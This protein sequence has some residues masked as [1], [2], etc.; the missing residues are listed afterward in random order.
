MFNPFSLFDD[1]IKK[2]IKRF[3]LLSNNFPSQ[4]AKFVLVSNCGFNNEVNDLKTSSQN[5]SHTAQL[6]RKINRFTRTME[7]EC[8]LSSATV[9]NVLSKLEFLKAPQFTD[10]DSKIIEAHLGNIPICKGLNLDVLRQILEEIKHLVYNASSKRISEP[11]NDY[12]SFIRKGESTK[13][14]LEIEEK[15]ITVAKV[16]GII[17]KNVDSIN[18]INASKDSLLEL[19][20]ID[21]VDDKKDQFPQLDIKIR[22]IGDR[23][24][25][26]K[27]A[28]IH[29]IRTWVLLNPWRPRAVRIS[30]NYNVIL[31]FQYPNIEIISLSQAIDPNDVDRFTL[32]LGSD[33]GPGPNKYV[34]QLYLLLLY[35]GDNKTIQ[36][37]D[38]LI[39]SRSPSKILGARKH[40]NRMEY[41]KEYNKKVLAEIKSI[42][43]I[44]S[45]TLTQIIK[46]YL[47]SGEVP[48]P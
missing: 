13:F 28:E 38:M 23:I 1:E 9:S 10:I 45:E 6:R 37:Q 22:N 26:L 20:D 33:Q 19:V 14:N 11:V 30:C 27:R 5:N 2:S 15:R 21:I 35:D 3:I 48:Y 36:T 34:Y 41:C 29:V 7:D 47:H 39:L 42:N 46:L 24:A 43:A 12:I 40:P 17:R 4:F 16:M 44:K 32:T 8:G 18:T 31:P 25:V